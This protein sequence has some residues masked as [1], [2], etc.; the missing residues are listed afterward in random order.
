MTRRNSCHNRAPFRDTSRVQGGWI[1]SGPSRVPVMKEIPFRMTRE[2]V[3]VTDVGDLA[4][5]GGLGAFDL[6]CDGCRWKQGGFHVGH[7][8]TG[9]A[10]G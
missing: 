1:E 9:S 4:R 7:C 2:C 6:G 5:K 3:Y 10:R 8:N